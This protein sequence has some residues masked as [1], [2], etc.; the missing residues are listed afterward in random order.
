MESTKKI[1]IVIPAFNEENQI[2]SVISSL[3][4]TGHNNILVVNDGSTDR[5]EEI[6]IR[7]G[8]EVLNHI[9]NRGQGSAIRTGIEY[10]KE[11]YDPDVIVT[12]DADGQHC[13]EDI[14][15]LIKPLEDNFDIV[16]GSRFLRKENKVP[17]LRKLILKA[18]I[19]FTKIVSNLELTDTHNGLRALG[20]KAIDSIKLSQ[21]GMD[22]ASEIIEEIRT[23][24]LKYKEVPV[25]IIYSDYSKT[26][27][28]NNSNF[29]KIALKVIIKKIAS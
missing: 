26:K 3:R 7:N 15:E 4:E 20:R 28:Q 27:G 24:E 22:Y 8:A 2:G 9:I 10:L 5:T 13:A 29:I 17:L 21:R 6:A 16:L 19:A 25:K 23:R 1:Y 14:S 12:F 11:N 18:G